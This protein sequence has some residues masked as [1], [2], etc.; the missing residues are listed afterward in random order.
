M[1][2]YWCNW[3]MCMCNRAVCLCNIEAYRCNRGCRCNR[4]AYIVIG[5]CTGVIGDVQM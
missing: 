1:E 3:V 5:W 2:A 4:E